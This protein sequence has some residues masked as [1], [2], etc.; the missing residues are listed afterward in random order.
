MAWVGAITAFFA[1]TIALTQTDLKRILAYSTISQ[2]GYMFLAVGVGAY[3][4]GHLPPGDPCLLQGAVVPGAGS[5]MHALAGE[6][7]IRK[8]GNLRAKMPV[9]YWTFLIGAAALA[10]IPLLSGFFSKDEILWSMPGRSR[11]SSGWSASSP[12]A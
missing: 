6:M 4:C 11:R 8:M 3:S 2:L 10:G 1:A 5:V 12:P 7:D 9:T